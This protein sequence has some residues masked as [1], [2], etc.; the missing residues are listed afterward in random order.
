MAGIPYGRKVAC[1]PREL[2]FQ[3]FCRTCGLS[4]LRRVN[5]IACPHAHF[6]PQPIVSAGPI[7][8]PL[9]SGPAVDFGEDVVQRY[10]ARNFAVMA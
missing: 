2:H 10:P 1:L 3:Q 5:A 9:R 4:G 8:R 7:L 6:G